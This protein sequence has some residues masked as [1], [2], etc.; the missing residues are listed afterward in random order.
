MAARNHSA[1]KLL[2]RS[3]ALERWA[4]VDDRTA[5]TEAARYGLKA[6]FLREA[7]PDGVLSEEERARRADRLSRAFYA[8]LAAKSVAARG[9]HG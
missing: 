9:R 4:R 1:R 2:A 6:K 8:R 5:A 7:D 3:A